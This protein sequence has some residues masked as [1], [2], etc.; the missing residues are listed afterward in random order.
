MV[1]PIRFALAFVLLLAELVIFI[2]VQL[3]LAGGEVI[4]S[5]SCACG[6]F[7]LVMKFGASQRYKQDPNH[8]SHTATL[9]GLFGE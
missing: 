3:N 4:V 8:I 2:L 6:Y 1:G 9:D 5:L 7:V